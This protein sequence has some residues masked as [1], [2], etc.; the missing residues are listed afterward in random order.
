MKESLICNECEAPIIYGE[1]VE[2]G[3]RKL[4]ISP[5]SCHASLASLN[6]QVG[7]IKQSLSRLKAEV[8]GDK[9]ISST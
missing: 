8:K 4:Y 2:D 7:I 3:I 9:E 5:C 1:I 6:A